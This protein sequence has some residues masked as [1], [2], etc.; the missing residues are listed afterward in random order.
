MNAHK[1]SVIGNALFGAMNELGHLWQI[2]NTGKPE[3][4]E[5][6]HTVGKVQNRIRKA[7]DILGG[8]D[9]LIRHGA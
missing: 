6:Q 5:R 4:M 2:K 9:F 8:V 7:V 3:D 1:K